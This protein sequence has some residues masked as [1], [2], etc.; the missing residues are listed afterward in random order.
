MTARGADAF[1]SDR[2]MV[3][4][5]LARTLACAASSSFPV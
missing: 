4:E 3:R 5:P 2:Y 1:R